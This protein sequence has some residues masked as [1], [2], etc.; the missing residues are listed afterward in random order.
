MGLFDTIIINVELPDGSS[1]IEQ[2][3][4]DFACAM[5]QYMVDE[6]GMLWYEPYGEGWQFCPS[7]TCIKTDNYDLHLLCGLLKGFMTREKEWIPFNPKSLFPTMTREELE[8]ALEQ[9]TG[10][11]SIRPM[12]ANDDQDYRCQ[13]AGQVRIMITGYS[14]SVMVGDPDEMPELARAIELRQHKEEQ[15]K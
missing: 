7:T 13:L 15:S 1:G 6:T 5:E 8:N 9:A 10:D 4:K 3:T 11:M 14:S 12:N 2:Q